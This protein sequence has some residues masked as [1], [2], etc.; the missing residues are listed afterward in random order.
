MTMGE[1]GKAAI[2]LDMGQKPKVV[3]GEPH[4][5]EM[6]QRN[7]LPVRTDD[8]F[9]KDLTQCFPPMMGSLAQHDWTKMDLINT[10]P[11]KGSK[12]RQLF[13]IG[14]FQPA[15]SYSEA[16]TPLFKVE[17]LLENDD[18][19]SL[20]FLW[21]SLVRHWNLRGKVFFMKDLSTGG[22]VPLNRGDP[23][24]E[25]IFKVRTQRFSQRPMFSCTW[26]DGKWYY[27]RAGI[28]VTHLATPK[29]TVGKNT[30]LKET[31]VFFDWCYKKEDVEEQNSKFCKSIS[32]FLKHRKDPTW[33]HL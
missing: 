14:T 29:K 26:L 8:A 4:G 31:G 1:R 11:K 5:G 23:A 12:I 10:P 21:L 24:E 9:W 28:P 2:F 33:T 19:F 27:I 30:Q 25:L 13:C 18:F 15:W 32:S 20:L 3:C 22:S 6:R 17:I 7:T 16:E